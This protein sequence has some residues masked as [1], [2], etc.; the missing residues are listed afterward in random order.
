[1][2]TTLSTLSSLKQALFVVIVPFLFW[3]VKSWHI[4]I[5]VCMCA[6]RFILLSF[7]LSPYSSLILFLVLFFFI[8]FSTDER[9]NEQ[10]IDEM[11][12]RTM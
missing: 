10:E 8:L 7:S 1:V 4:S 2:S 11:M 3:P 9:K 5:S 6:M 12:I